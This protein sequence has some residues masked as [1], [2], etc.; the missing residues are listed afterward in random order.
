VTF[1]VAEANPVDLLVDHLRLSG[2]AGQKVLE[3]FEQ[4]RPWHGGVRSLADDATQGR[5]SMRI[6]CKPGITFIWRDGFDTAFSLCDYDRIKFSWKMTG[7]QG[8]WSNSLV[9]RVDTSLSDFHVPIRQ[10]SAVVEDAQAESRGGDHFGTIRLAKYFTDDS[11]LTRRIVLLREGALVVCDDLEPGPQAKGQVA[12]PI[13]HLH[14]EPQSGPH[15]F[16]SPGPRRLL[17][18]FAPSAGREFGVQTVELWGHTRP[19]TTF[20]KQPLRPNCPVRFITVL[21][22]HGDERS[23]EELAGQIASSEDASGSHTVRLAMPANEIRISIA[24][25]GQCRVA[26]Q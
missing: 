2:P 16:D 12:G 5:H 1:R 26:R 11:R 6:A 14:A 10:L 4:L 23:P 22:P 20:A 24:R 25:D 19:Y 17:I 9:F 3:D 21:V 18:W 7:T 15:W 8:G 13:W